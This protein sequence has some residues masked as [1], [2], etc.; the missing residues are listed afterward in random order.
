MTDVTGTATEVRTFNDL[1]QLL[2]NAVTPVGG[3]TTNW[4][5]TW[6]LDGTLATKSDGTNIYAYAWDPG[7]DQRLLSMSLNGVTQVAFT[8]DSLGRMLTRTPY[9]AGVAQAPTNF[10]WDHW[11]CVRE[12]APAGTY[13]AKHARP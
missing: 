3:G 8:Y 10:E 2:S 1:N 12:F 7:G 13:R 11:D 5:Y 4:T 6:N 9:S